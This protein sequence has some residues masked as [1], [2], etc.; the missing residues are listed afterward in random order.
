MHIFKDYQLIGDTLYKRGINESKHLL[1]KYG[2]VPA[3][4][5]KLWD[6]WYNKILEIKVTTNKGRTFTIPGGLFDLNKELIN[7]GYGDQYVVEKLYWEI[8]TAK[9]PN[10]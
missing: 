1:W 9:I 6:S 3:I 8:E 4:D 10:K 2:G 7:L 5:R